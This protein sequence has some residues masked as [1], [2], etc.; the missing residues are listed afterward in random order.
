MNSTLKRPGSPAP[1]VR[2]PAATRGAAGHR[3]RTLS[4]EQIDRLFSSVGE[5]L[6]EGL[7]K[8]AEKILVSAIEGHAHTP[9]DLANLKRLLSFTL[10]TIGRYRES[11]EILKPFENE[12]HL[13]ILRRH[14]VELVKGLLAPA[15]ID[16]KA[17]A[18]R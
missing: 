14:I 7:S 12:E 3:H 11:L 9:D 2:T 6:R 8:E 13:A 15:N 10:E 4:Q 5:K 17:H 18:I 16:R 1:A